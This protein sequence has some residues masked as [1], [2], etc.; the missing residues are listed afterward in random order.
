MTLVSYFLA[1]I[2]GLVISLA[3]VKNSK[4]DDFDGMA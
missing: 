1:I 2:A 4:D 3:I